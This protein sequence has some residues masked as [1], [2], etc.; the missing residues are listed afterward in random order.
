MAKRLDRLQKQLTALEREKVELEAA[1]A[2]L[3]RG[4]AEKRQALTAAQARAERTP[5]AENETVAS[6]L[7]HEVTG[8]A[9]QLERKRA[10][11]A[12]VDVDLVNARAAVAKADRAAACAE[13]SALLDQVAD[14]AGQVD[15]DVSNV[16]AWARLQ[17][18]VD[19]TNTL[20]RERIGTAG[21]FRVIFGTSPRELLPRVF[22]WHQARAAAAVG[23]GKPPQQPGA[24]SQLLNLGHA[25]ARIKRLLP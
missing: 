15:A 4:Q 25:Q 9:G 8:L 17:T 12:Q 7:E 5:S 22:A 6:G 13:L 10:A 1:I 21:E 23:A 2:D 19:D 20:Y 16:A 14:A 3:G 24:L 11:L 18:A